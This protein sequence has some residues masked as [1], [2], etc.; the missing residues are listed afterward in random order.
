MESIDGVFHSPNSGDTRAFFM[1]RGKDYVFDFDAGGFGCLPERQHLPFGA[2]TGRRGAV[3]VAGA[4]HSALAQGA[5]VR[6]ERCG[7]A[8]VISFRMRN[9][10]TD[11]VG[12]SYE[13]G[14]WNMQNQLSRDQRG[15]GKTGGSGGVGAI[16][17]KRQQQH[18]GTRN[19]AGSISADRAA[20][21]HPLPAGRSRIHRQRLVQDSAQAQNPL[22]HAPEAQPDCHTAGR[23]H[24]HHFAFGKGPAI[25]TTAGLAENHAW[26]HEN[27]SD[28]SAPERRRIAGGGASWSGQARPAHAIP[29]ALE[30]RDAVRLFETQ[31]IQS[32]RH[33]PDAQRQAGKNL[34]YRSNSRRLDT[35]SR[36]AKHRPI[37]KKNH[38]YHARS[39]FL[40]GLDHILATL[41]KPPNNL[42]KKYCSTQK[43][44]VG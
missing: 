31:G 3:C 42:M 18:E 4:A 17:K 35:A 5:D 15:G 10:K 6:L 7:Q 29:R 13:L 32:R 37:T 41:Y 27:R 11:G 9:E 36:W 24:R 23:R 20:L 8:V 43:D 16:G 33:T 39:I 22:R 14:F 28:H 1:A 40:R 21:A 19:S 34:R 12:G 2:T 25:A 44:N 30:N 38:G 26:K